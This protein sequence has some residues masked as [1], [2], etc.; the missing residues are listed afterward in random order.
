ML[1]ITSQTAIQ[2]IKNQNR[3]N[4]DGSKWY[5]LFTLILGFVLLVFSQFISTN[6]VNNKQEL[7]ASIKKVIDGDTML[8]VIND[9]STIKCR[10]LGIDTPEKFDSD[11]LDKFLK[12]Y[13]FNKE[14][15]QN[16]GRAS[17]KFAENFFE[18]EKKYYIKIS[19]KDIYDRDLCIIKKDNLIYNKEVLREGY[20]I[21]YKQGRYTKPES[22]AKELSQLQYTAIEHKKGLWNSH[23]NLMIKMTID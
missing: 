8:F 17:T 7:V 5:L 20:A 4:N 18:N 9:N 14:Q 2:I 16:A 13:N 6:E 11:K 1:K 12:K 3:K 22:L 19:G 10:V 23:Y 21:V 15:V